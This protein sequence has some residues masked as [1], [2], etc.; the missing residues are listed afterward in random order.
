MKNI[1]LVVSVVI[2]CAVGIGYYMFGIDWDVQPFVPPKGTVFLRISPETTIVTEPL[3]PGGT[4]IDFFALL[5]QKCS[6]GA[7]SE[8]NG[9]REIVR[10]VGRSIFDSISDKEWN[11]LCEKLNLNPDDPPQFHYEPLPNDVSVPFY[12]DEISEESLEQL[13]RWVTE[14]EPAISAVAEALK[15]PLYIIPTVGKVDISGISEFEA[16]ELWDIVEFPSFLPALLAQRI[17][18]RMFQSRCWFWN[19]KQDKRG[20]NDVLSMF[21]IAR[22]VGRQSHPD[23]LAIADA[24][25]HAAAFRATEFLKTVE[26]N[27]DKLRQCL[28]D[29]DSLPD[30][31]GFENRLEYIRLG[32]LKNIS[33]FP[34]R[35]PAAFGIYLFPTTFDNPMFMYTTE[36]KEAI[37]FANAETR[38][39]IQIYRTIPFDWIIVAEM[40]NVEFDDQLGKPTKQTIF[41]S[42]PA[43]RKI[44]DEMD[45][46]KLSFDKTLEILESGSL[47]QQIEATRPLIDKHWNRASLKKMTIEERSVYLGK[48]FFASK[49]SIHEIE[50]YQ[51]RSGTAHFEL[52]RLT[53]ALQL[54]K[55]EQGNYPA[56]L[57]ELVAKEYLPVI[58]NDP[59]R[60]DGLVPFI[61]RVE[62]DGS[63][64][65]Y[66]VGKNGIDDG[67]RRKTSWSSNDLDRWDDIVVRLGADKAE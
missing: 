27:A 32:W 18:I 12:R 28:T 45:V 5:D 65:V 31:S 22:H 1:I 11:I 54:H 48:M 10:L 36:Y 56:S 6:A 25:E 67:G 50:T 16:L 59:Y 49:A 26:L 52:A 46:P 21:H 4:A 2:L 13:G 33:E 66:S 41:Q 63:C 3:L 51:R 8:E 64:I 39:I 47:K 24:F 58:P 55:V 57:D 30:W 17:V 19:A 61:Y 40:M 53:I 20:W 34:K 44:Y 9:F 29:L 7:D 35:G 60:R 37:R 38:K 43:L 42:N 23:A 62:A 15:R 14:M